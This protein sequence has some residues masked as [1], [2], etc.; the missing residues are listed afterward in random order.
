MANQDIQLTNAA[1]MLGIN[2]IHGEHDP[3]GDYTLIEQ[4]DSARYAKVGDV[5]ELTVTNATGAHHPFHLHGFSIQPISLTD[6]QAGANPPT[7][8]KV[9]GIGPPYTFPYREFRDN[10][11]VPAGYT[12]T[13]RVRL[14]D[15][16]L[17]DGTTLGGALGRWVFHCHIFFHASFGMISEFDVVSALG[18]EAPTVNSDATQV[19]VDAGQIAMMT[20]TYHDPDGDAVTL[21]SSIGS[22]IDTGGGTWKWTYLTT[23]ALGEPGPVYITGTDTAGLKGQAVFSL[24]V[25]PTAKSLK[26]NVLAQANA[27]LPGLPKQDADKLEDAINKLGESLDPALWIDS[28]HIVD[29]GGNR[30]FDLEK[31]AATKL[32]D[33]IKDNSIPDATLQ[34]MIASLLLADSMLAEQALADAI[35]AAGDP[36]K[37]AEAQ[38]ELAKAEEAIVK[39]QINAA[40][41]HFKNAWRNAL[42]A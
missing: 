14:D 17:M 20:G 4:P 10:I 8:D 16:P 13:F 41:D 35:A 33:L 3:M 34:D 30:V 15:R 7:P 5:L 26:Q 29:K 25:N 37:I 36:M 39:G 22:V 40:I 31:Y 12:L 18:N 32:Q 23:G 27:L 24:I 9:P 11:D 28:N 2:G 19:Q 21:S 6:T 38:K 42:D 1:N